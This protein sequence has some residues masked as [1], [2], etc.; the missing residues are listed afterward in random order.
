MGSCQD[1][2]ELVR[3]DESVDR[4]EF[5]EFVSGHELCNVLQSSSWAKVKGWSYALTGVRGE[6]GTLL[7][8]GLVLQR[9]LP[10]GLSFWY[11]PHGPVLNFDEPGVLETYLSGLRRWAK[12]NRAV[13]VRIDPFVAV[14][15][16]RLGELPDGYD[17]GARDIGRRIEAVAYK[18]RGFV[19][20][21]HATLQPRFMPVCVRPDG[22][23][24]DYQAT[25][26]KKSRTLA[27][28]AR[29][30]HVE[31]TRGGK[32]LL[33]PFLE[34]IAQTEE[35][36]GIKLRSRPYYERI[37]DVFGDDARIYLATL[38]IA[39]SLAKYRAQVEAAQAELEVTAPNAA[40]KIARLTASIASA[41]KHIA[42]LE[43]RRGVDGDH[44]T[45]A[46]VLMVR[47]GSAAEMLYAGTNRNYGSIPAQH[48]M[49]VEALGEGFADGLKTVSLGGVDGSL[50]DSLMRFKSRFEPEIV[51]KIGEF[52]TNIIGPVAAAIDLYLARR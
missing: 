14:R 2:E 8:V 49:W 17:A 16:A 7:G 26:S 3:F 52:Q 50:T 46:G 27:N 15:R 48:L 44:V 18:H 23:T 33:D 31:I 40:K 19:T 36:K 41:R 6:D 42:E 21:I 22:F 39:D 12:K 1:E 30:R 47:F 37:L 32:E 20:D 43:E 45:L 29:N 24:G 4:A 5:D 10:L 34:V 28:N 11:L 9:R 35:E 13:A 25:L 51:E 38:D